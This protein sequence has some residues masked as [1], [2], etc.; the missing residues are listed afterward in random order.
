MGKVRTGPESTGTDLIV[1][2][3]DEAQEALAEPERS[4]ERKTEL[5]DLLGCIA[6][7]RHLEGADGEWELAA[8]LWLLKMARKKRGVSETQMLLLKALVKGSIQ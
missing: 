6:R 8:V 3:I 2:A 5:L 1:H 4:L 7:L